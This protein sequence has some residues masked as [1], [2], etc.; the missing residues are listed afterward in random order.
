MD[1]KNSGEI[2]FYETF[3]AEEW[4]IKEK[5]DTLTFISIDENEH[6]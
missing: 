4:C 3:S 2:S 5:W 6:G 1:S